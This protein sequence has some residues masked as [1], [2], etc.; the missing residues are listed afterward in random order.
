MKGLGGMILAVVAVAAIGLLG[1]KGS[2]GTQGNMGGGASLPGP[3][4]QGS[5]GLLGGGVSSPMGSFAQV[6]ASAPVVSP[7]SQGP[8]GPS[9]TTPPGYTVVQ[10]FGGSGVYVQVPISSIPP[11]PPGQ[12]NPI[13]PDTGL[14]FTGAQLTKLASGSD[15]F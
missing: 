1:S 14:R 5:S 6:L 8:Q 4:K 7:I 3:S 10:T 2:G 13:N 9:F 15:N 11:G 12:P